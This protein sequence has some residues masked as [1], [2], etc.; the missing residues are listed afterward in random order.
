MA[1]KKKRP[2]NRWQNQDEQIVQKVIL[3]QTKGRSEEVLVNLWHVCLWFYQLSCYVRFCSIG[4]SN[5]WWLNVFLVKPHLAIIFKIVLSVA[6]SLKKQK[7]GKNWTST[8]WENRPKRKARRGSTVAGP[9][10][11]LQL[12]LLLYSIFSGSAEE[13]QTTNIKKSP[14][15]KTP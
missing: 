9:I 7:N 15:K 5:I 12:S 8:M 2:V 3:L 10:M 14:K 6:H 11:V 1:N 13:N 4:L